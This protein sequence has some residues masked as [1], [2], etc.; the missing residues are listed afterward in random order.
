MSETI[1][2]V[3][4]MRLWAAMLAAQASLS[5]VAKDATNTQ[6][7]YRYASAEGMIQVCRDALHAHGLAL[8]RLAAGAE[9]TSEREAIARGGDRYIV[10]VGTW[11]AEY[12]VVHAESGESMKLL[13]SSPI[14][15]GPGRPRDK[16]AAGADTVA[17]RYMLRGLLLVPQVE[18]GTDEQTGSE[19]PPPPPPRAQRVTAP[20]SVTPANDGAAQ[21]ARLAARAKD[22][23]P[24]Y[25]T[26]GRERAREFYRSGDLSGL[27]SYLDSYRAPAPE[28]A[29]AAPA[30]SPA[31]PCRP[32][33][34]PATARTAALIGG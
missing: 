1:E 33:G 34:G 12:L 14:E 29:P 24:A 23:I 13:A 28:K 5:G 17:L 8:V 6:M 9:W 7:R 19:E 30:D 26:A 18:P 31:A 4:E 3:T 25:D 27:E 32:G 21:A 2:Q 16:A 11:R 15:T 20:P 10:D 22:E